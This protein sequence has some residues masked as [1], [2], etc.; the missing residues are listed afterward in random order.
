MKDKNVYLLLVSATP[1][2]ELGINTIDKKIFTL[3]PAPTYYGIH[4]M[5]EK[6]RIYDS[7][8]LK[9][10]NLKTEVEIGEELENLLNTMLNHYN[11]PA[12]LLSVRTLEV[13][14]LVLG[15]NY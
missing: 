13:N 4:K 15:L 1:F 9:I 5:I 2:S 3:Q 10:F 12:L 14:H 11:K 6:K 8:S 7:R